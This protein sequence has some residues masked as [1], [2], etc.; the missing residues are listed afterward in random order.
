METDVRVFF[1]E[2][3]AE[4]KDALKQYLNPSLQAGY[5]EKTIQEY[6][7]EKPPA[8]IIST[9][10]QSHVP[11]EWAPRL[12]ALLTRSTGYEHLQ[13][14]RNR[15]AQS[16]RYGYLPLYCNRAVAEQAALLW[17]SLLRKLPLQIDHMARFNRDGLTGI[18]CS[19]KHSLLSE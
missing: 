18:E 6:G 1:F 2:A 17:M 13:A 8:S 5:S 7:A 3:F 14:Y 10:T 11:L 4:E 19:G 12:E 16:I 9:R 15:T